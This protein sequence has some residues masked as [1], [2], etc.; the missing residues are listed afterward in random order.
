MGTANIILILI[1]KKDKTG[2]KNG[3]NASCSGY[4]N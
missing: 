4:K 3:K 1:K 2:E